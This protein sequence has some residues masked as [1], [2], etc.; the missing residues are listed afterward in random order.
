M[1]DTKRHNLL[2]ILSLSFVLVGW[3]GAV[4]ALEQTQVQAAE[5]SVTVQANWIV[6]ISLSMGEPVGV[7]LFGLW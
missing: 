6:P 5:S 2:R 1:K 4:Q 3:T 7:E